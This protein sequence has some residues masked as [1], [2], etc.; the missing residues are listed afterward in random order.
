MTMLIAQ[1][2]GL[3]TIICMTMTM[4]HYLEMVYV[5]IQDFYN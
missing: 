2:E 4:T 5:M 1:L 3:S